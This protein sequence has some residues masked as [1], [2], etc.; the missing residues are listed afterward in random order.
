MKKKKKKKK[1]KRKKKKCTHSLIYVIDLSSIYY[2]THTIDDV[3]Q[4]ILLKKKKM[5]S[6][7]PD[8]VFTDFYQCWQILCDQAHSTHGSSESEKKE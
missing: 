1:K 4:F 2:A 7:I 8:G 5:V 3:L 6:C